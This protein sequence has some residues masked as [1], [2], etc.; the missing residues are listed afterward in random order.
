MVPRFASKRPQMKSC[1][2]FKGGFG[3]VQLQTMW[4]F[5]LLD[6]DGRNISLAQ[7]TRNQAALKH[8]SS[9][10]DPVPRKAKVSESQFFLVYNLHRPHEQ[11]V[12]KSLQC[13]VQFKGDLHKDE[14]IEREKGAYPWRQWTGA[15]EAH[16]RDKCL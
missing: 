9:L 14:C 2:N 1:N 3:V 8:C 4:L 10:N 11:P 13:V 6:N 15:H 12:W 7:Q 16:R 5:A